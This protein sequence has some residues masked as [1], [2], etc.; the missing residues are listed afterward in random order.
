M[1]I[2]QQI[3]VLEV[4]PEKFVDNCSDIEL[5]EAILLADAKLSRRVA[6]PPSAQV[7]A[8][9]LPASPKPE[10]RAP[11]KRGWTAEE[12]VRLREL[13]PTCTGSEAAKTLKR[14]YKAV[15]AHAIM[16]GL[17]KRQSKNSVPDA[18]QESDSAPEAEDPTPAALKSSPKKKIF[19]RVDKRTVVLAPAGADV[20][21]L[22]QKYSV[23]K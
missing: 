23:N 5:R 18:R 3:Y 6:T 13:W 12:D 4:T 15:M 14:D 20:E 2:L 7:P 17:R 22:K 16:L 10:Q 11:K 8:K 19:V 9:T 21:K 1:P